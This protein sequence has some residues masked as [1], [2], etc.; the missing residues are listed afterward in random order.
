MFHLRSTFHHLL[1]FQGAYYCLSCS[2]GSDSLYLNFQKIC[3]SVKEGIQFYTYLHFLMYL[4]GS[5]ETHSFP[6]NPTKLTQ[7]SFHELW[8]R[9]SAFSKR[10]S[11]L[12]PKEKKRFLFWIYVADL[13]LPL[14]VAR[15][16]LHRSKIPNPYRPY[17]MRAKIK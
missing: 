2:I 14:Q 7:L 10:F 8:A 12:F 11:L 5:R 13:Y 17:A 9:K 15:H 6:C 4:N 1:S 3:F 16:A